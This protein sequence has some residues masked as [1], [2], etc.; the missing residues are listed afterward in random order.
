[1]VEGF[2]V[3]EGVEGVG[4]D[5]E[6]VEETGFS[7]DV[8]GSEEDVSGSEEVT[9]SSLDESV[10]EEVSGFDISEVT[11]LT[12][13]SETESLSDFLQAVK[14]VQISIAATK[15]ASILKFFFINFSPFY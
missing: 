7:E 11:V 14:Q 1:M 5:A 8:V 4:F 6:G 12:A 2:G 9:V 13:E 3:E 15:S 10:L